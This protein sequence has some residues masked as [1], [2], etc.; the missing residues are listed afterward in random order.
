MK[1]CKVCGTLVH[2]DSI[3][4]PSCGNH[5]FFVLDVKICPLCGKVNR[6]TSSFCEQCGKQ[7]SVP[8]GVGAGVYAV[9]KPPLNVR[10]IAYRE[11]E[12]KEPYKEQYKEPVKEPVKESYKEPEKDFEVID[13]PAIKNKPQDLAERAYKDFVALKPQISENDDVSEYS[14]YV[15]GDGDKLPVVIL[16]KF[17]KTQGKNIIVNI[18]LGQ[19]GQEAAAATAAPEQITEPRPQ[20]RE[21]EEEKVFKPFSAIKEEPQEEIIETPKEIEKEEPKPEPAKRSFK[22]AKGKGSAGAVFASLL[23]ALLSLGII[24]SYILVFFNSQVEAERTSGASIVMYLVNDLF[25]LNIPLPAIFSD[26]YAE[27]VMARVLMGQSWFSGIF[28]Q[29]AHLVPYV[30]AGA[31]VVSLINTIIVLS[32]FKHRRWAKAVLIFTGILLVLGFAAMIAAIALI[33]QADII[34]TTGLGLILAAVASLVF[35]ILTIA[36]YKPRR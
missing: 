29:F 9:K 27:F 13:K 2:I 20:Q 16:P 25:N 22:K 23:M 24:A 11:K 30:A 6:K 32:T 14:Y 18:V 26:G 17:A 12:Q 36:A 8:Q 15:Q 1:Q 4:C 10:P 3:T 35:L 28:G 33:Y 19:Q 31:V 34:G 5:S 21:N 7:F